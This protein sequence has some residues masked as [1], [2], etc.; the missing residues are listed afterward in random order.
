MTIPFKHLK[1]GIIQFSNKFIYFSVMKHTAPIQRQELPLENS[2]GNF[3]RLHF[4]GNF[5]AKRMKSMD[6]GSTIA[7]LSLF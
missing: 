7:Q 6:V 2:L 4:A 5:E 3:S 1:Q